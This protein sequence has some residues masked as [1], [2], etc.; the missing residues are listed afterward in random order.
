MQMM[1]EIL[2]K[3]GSS[4]QLDLPISEDEPPIG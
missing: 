1:N 2:P 3:R 4:I